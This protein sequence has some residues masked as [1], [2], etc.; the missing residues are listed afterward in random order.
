MTFSSR[1]KSQKPAI[2][3]AHGGARRDPEVERL[4]QICQLHGDLDALCDRALSMPPSDE[5]D[6]VLAE[7]REIKKLIGELRNG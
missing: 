6:L 1:L 7:T 3:A 2:S 5:R 4:L